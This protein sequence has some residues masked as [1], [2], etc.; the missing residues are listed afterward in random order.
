[1]TAAVAATAGSRSR[2]RPTQQGRARVRRRGRDGGDRPRRSRE[3]HTARSRRS[4]APSAAS[5]SP[6]GSAL[7]STPGAAARV[8]TRAASSTP[9]ASRTRR[10]RSS[11][12]AT[13][14]CSASDV[15]SSR[16]SSS[17][18]STCSSATR[19]TGW[20]RSSSGGSSPS[21]AVPGSCLWLGAPRSRRPAA[22][23]RRLLR[24]RRRVPR[25]PVPG[26]IAAARRPTRLSLV[27]VGSGAL[28]LAGAL[29]LIVFKYSSPTRL[30]RRAL[31]PFLLAMAAAPPRL[32]RADDPPGDRRPTR[33]RSRVR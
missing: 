13:R 8:A 17:S 24:L 28:A 14:G 9:S 4:R 6:R 1:M 29:I 11:R 27:A 5:S 30:R 16:R 22:V 23:R 32:R 33:C 31:E 25:E 2:G 20:R 15:C 3:P 10:R 7:R 19:A 12:R 26:R 18:S 21:S